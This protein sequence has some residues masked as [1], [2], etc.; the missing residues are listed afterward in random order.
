MKR[1]FLVSLFVVSYVVIFSQEPFKH[2][3]KMYKAPDGKLYINKALPVYVWLSTSPDP[4][5]SKERLMSEDSKTWTNPF[6][7]DTEGF[8]SIRTPSKVDTVTRKPII[9]Q[10]DIIW[11]VYAD[12]YSP[13]TQVQYEN[14]SLYKKEKVY[15]GAGL[16]VRLIS[17]DVMSGVEKVFASMN[18]APFTEFSAPIVCD[19]E[20]EYVIKFYAVDNVG[21]A[22][23]VLTKTFAVDRTAP[24]TRLE[25][26]GDSSA[27]IFSSR[28]MI[29]FV[30]SDNLSGVKA[31]M[32]SFDDQKPFAYVS[33]IPASYFKEGEH[34]VVFYATDN[35]GNVEQSQTYNF[36]LDK[37]PPVLI[38][39][40][41][42][43]TYF[44]NGKEYTSGRSKLKL[45]AIDNKAGVKEIY[46]TTNGKFYQ[47]Y[48][49]PFY[50]PSVAGAMQINFYAVDNVS[51]KTTG[52]ETG[53][54]F[55]ATYMDLSGPKLS[56]KFIGL[57]FKNRDTV[58][59]NSSTKIS[60]SAYDE[61]SGMKKIMYSV[62]GDNEEQYSQPLTIS[63][64]GVYQLMYTA[65]DQVNNT[66]K[67]TINFIVDNTG[68]EIFER[69]SIESVG[70]KNG[71]MVYPAHTVV[72][73]SATD[74]D[75]GYDKM[76]C[77]INDGPVV[78]NGG[79]IN[80]LKKNTKYKVK[81]KAFDK[82]GSF[83]EK[84]IEFMTGD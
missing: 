23:Q 2:E 62:N 61:E 71:L 63:K 13:T 66:N 27:N 34:K 69:Y 25:I 48:T 30:S 3:K 36:Y 82:L 75:S 81:I 29:K 80:G 1:I 56:Y 38:D 42:G 64:E 46:Y 22:E 79:T 49:E 9:P 44:V 19:N 16:Q 14:T 20:S 32:V 17:N 76:V 77:S 47:L 70:K 68:P 73:L 53:S 60:I 72:F 55:R 33:R 39:E 51:N 31:I 8:N 11:E 26:D 59:I 67:S 24:I 5:S 12:S 74:K 54:K 65:Y 18:G 6:Y 84:T 21:N 50:L 35:V 10:Q 83:K 52:S 15:A 37:T 58:F 7:F 4:N 57:T 28:S 45:T 78:P 41:L 43:D 40:L